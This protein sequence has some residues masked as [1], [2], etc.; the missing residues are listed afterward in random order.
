MLEEEKFLV[1]EI[2]SNKNLGV[3]E[4]EALKASIKTPVIYD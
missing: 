1:E 4:K 2:D 3:D